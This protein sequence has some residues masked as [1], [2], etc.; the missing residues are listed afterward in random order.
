MIS[1]KR[2]DESNFIACFH[3]KLGDGQERFVSTP[4]RSL[5]LAYVY[6][7]QCMPFGIYAGD[8]MVGY[9]L[10]IYDYDEQ[11]YNIWHLMIDE[12]EQHKGY[13]KAALQQ[14]LRYIRTKPF[15]SSDQVSLTCAPDNTVAYNLY[16]SLGFTKTGRYDDGE[17]ELA[18]KLK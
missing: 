10:V 11:A 15:G 2:I 9:T 14:V 16:T 6:Y 8:T 4:V 7:R 5:A 18:L 17:M 1:L 3:L 12:A 13:G